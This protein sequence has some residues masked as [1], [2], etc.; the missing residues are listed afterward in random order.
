MTEASTVT[1]LIVPDRVAM[2]QHLEH[3][4]GGGLDGYHDGLIEISWD[5]KWKGAGFQS[6]LFP[7]TDIDAAV[8]EAAKQNLIPKQNVYIG[9]TLRKPDTPPFGRASDDDFYASTC[10]W[11]DLD[12]EGAVEAAKERWAAGKPT[13]IVVTGRVPHKRL[14]IWWRL[15]EPITDPA[16]LRSITEGMRDTFGGDPT[17]VNVSNLMRLGGTIAWPLKP[18]RVLERTEVHTPVGAPSF[19]VDTLLN[20]AYPPVEPSG[21]RKSAGISIVRTQ[22]PTGSLG[23]SAEGIV[24]DGREQYMRDTVMACFI[25]YVGENGCAP[26][27]Q[28]LFDI[29]WPQYAAKASFDRP[30]RREGEMAQK[31][32]S[33]L[34]RFHSGRIR[35]L[36]DLDDVVRAYQAKPKRERP[37]ARAAVAA[38]AAS[39]DGPADSGLPLIWFREI[40]PVVDTADLVEDLLGEQQMSVIY[41]ES[42]CGKTFFGL[43]VSAHIAIARQWRGKAVEGGG[44]I[45]VACEGGFGIRN[46]VSAFA[47]H[48]GLT[49]QDIPLAIVP[50]AINLLDPEADTPRLIELIKR[51][52]DTIQQQVRHLTV[53]TLS[54]AMAGGNENSPD[55]MGA[56]VINSDRIRQATGAH[57][58]FIHHSG[59][60]AAKG[61]RGHSL[62]RAATDTEIEVTRDPDAKVST[63][64]ATKQRE[65]PIEGA[66]VFSLES[67]V[68]G[69]N[70]RGKDITS[71][72]VKAI[73]GDAPAREVKLTPKEARAITE[74]QNVLAEQGKFV[75]VRDIPNVPV[76]PALAW[77]ERLHRVGGTSRDNPDTARKEWRRIV[78][79]LEFK[80]KIRQCD[81]YVWMV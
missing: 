55:D 14:Q 74:L 16:Y 77:K 32:K 24:Q 13:K 80:G 62:L 3:L 68:L 44:V 19:Y 11:T 81:G 12:D 25:E 60:D 61:A 18:G 26:E 50:S 39:E 28:E 43:D 33:T 57:F 67:I 38:A 70:K 21:A 72:V 56:L 31:V 37:A 65:M 4:F 40:E 73:E 34:Q 71:C 53:D 30:G 6:A 52:Q 46:R 7:V 23:L 75:S 76:C 45:Y 22:A 51:A 54:R 9:A 41:G 42:N 8:E 59:K 27:P 79:G 15:E 2:R 36:K 20:D 49:G 69:Q 58:S 1:E 10:V 66:F 48:Y 63:A 17:V 47:K 5:A 35:D 78:E 64:R 29:A